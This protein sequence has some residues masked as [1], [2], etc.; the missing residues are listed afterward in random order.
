M[1]NS[2]SNSTQGTEV[3]NYT[4]GKMQGQVTIF[5]EKQQYEWNKEIYM[6]GTTIYWRNA[7][8]FPLA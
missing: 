5:N 2:N 3:Q 4:S 7:C 6:N 8:I 1:N